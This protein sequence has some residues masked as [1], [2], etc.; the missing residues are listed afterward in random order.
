MD[1]ERHNKGLTI[2]TEVR[3]RRKTVSKLLYLALSVHEGDTEGTQVKEGATV[4]RDAETG[5]KS[6]ISGYG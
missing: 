5:G 3:D 4:P 1:G 2:T 6:R